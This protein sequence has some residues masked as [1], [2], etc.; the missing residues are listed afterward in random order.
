MS[1]AVDIEKRL[2]KFNLKVAFECRESEVL[3]VLGASG[4]GKS[5]TLKCIAGLITPDAGSIVLNGRVL[6]DAK[7][8]INL[9]PQARCV[10]YLF[11]SYA[12]F[13][14]MTLWQNI[15]CAVPKTVKD[16]RAVVE[17][18][19]DRFKLCGFEKHYP[20]EL[21]GGQQQ[22]AAL[23][24]IL[25]YAPEVLLLDEPFSALD[26]YLREE[27]QL[28]MKAML[29][30]YGGDVLMVTHNRDEAY[31]LGQNMLILHEGRVLETGLTK[32]VFGHPKTLAAA[33]LTGCKNIS[34]AQKL[35]DKKVKAIDWGCEWDAFYE[36]PDNITHVGVRAHHFALCKGHA[37]NAFRVKFS[38]KVETPFEWDVLFT[39]IA[40]SG[41][42]WLKCPKTAKIDETLEHLCVLPED[43]LL[44]EE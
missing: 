7:K 23:A 1:L 15:D 24:R 31:K 37:Q 36:V 16:R 29:E 22:R 40:Q 21:S 39:T 4:S 18:L 12:L 8:R 3:G 2:G 32:D 41:K 33:R 43:I 27:M 30:G 13:P 17:K 26:A 6:F 35:G 38:E 11:Q 5:V 19:V 28:E 9:K 20:H 42:I 14:H 44:L 25:A 34:R 10:G